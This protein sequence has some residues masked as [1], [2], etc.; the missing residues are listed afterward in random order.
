MEPASTAA[1]GIDLVANV[2]PALLIVIGAPLG[3][4]FWFKRGRG[5]SDESIAACWRSWTATA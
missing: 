1:S 3:I 4:W 5:S 2:V